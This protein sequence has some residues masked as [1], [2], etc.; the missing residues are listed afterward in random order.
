MID[1]V[2]ACH[3]CDKKQSYGFKYY[4]YLL[5]QKTSKCVCVTENYNARTKHKDCPRVDEL[6]RKEAQ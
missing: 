6:Y 3:N 4:C 2:V 5:F 1:Y